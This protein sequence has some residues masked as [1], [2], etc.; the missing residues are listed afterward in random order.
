MLARETEGD[1]RANV[2]VGGRG[3]RGAYEAPALARASRA[4]TLGTP[5][6]LV[7]GMRDSRSPPS[8]GPFPAERRRDPTTEPRSDAYR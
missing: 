3:A 7:A 1:E 6:S 5:T 4:A 2:R 8:A